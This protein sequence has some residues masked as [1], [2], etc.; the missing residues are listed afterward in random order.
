MWAR[1]WRNGVD[2]D[3]SA[4]TLRHA[5]AMA[6]G[7]PICAKRLAKLGV[8]HHQRVEREGPVEPARVRQNPSHRPGKLTGKPAPGQLRLPKHRRRRALAE[9][10]DRVRLLASNPSRAATN[11]AGAIS[12]GRRVGLSTTAVMPQP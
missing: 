10:G 11:S 8:G 9:K 5:G 7:A 2:R 6:G 4:R 12:P 1:S 3:H